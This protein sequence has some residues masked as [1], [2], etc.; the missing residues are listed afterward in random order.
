[1]AKL[2]YDTYM[3]IWMAFGLGNIARRNIH[4]APLQVSFTHLPQ[5]QLMYTIR[6]HKGVKLSVRVHSFVTKGARFC[7]RF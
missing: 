1:M 6:L 4:T 3:N 7:S 5:R 2:W